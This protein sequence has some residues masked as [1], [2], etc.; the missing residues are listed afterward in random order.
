M[1]EN[2]LQKRSSCFGAVLSKSWEDFGLVEII[3]E[4]AV[5]IMM[6]FFVKSVGVAKSDE[7]PELIILCLGGAIITP[8][9]GLIIRIIFISPHR[10][11]KEQFE[12]HRLLEEQLAEKSEAD[13]LVVEKQKAKTMI[14]EAF[15]DLNNRLREA[16]NLSRLTFKGSTMDDEFEKTQRIIDRV[17][18][19]FIQHNLFAEAARY[20]GALG[21]PVNEI[22]SDP[23][24]GQ[25]RMDWQ[26]H[27]NKIAAKLDKLEEII[28]ELP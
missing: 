22:L 10:I 24:Y 28:K 3:S 17:A 19:I 12:K 18:G 6:A 26:W 20:M 9:F 2:H 23:D 4:G 27:V 7:M 11:I 5:G 21:L 15:V 8:L 14:A 13:K 25:S 1:A 16:Y